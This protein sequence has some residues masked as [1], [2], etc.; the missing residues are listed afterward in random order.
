MLCLSLWQLYYLKQFVCVFSV[1]QWS[2]PLISSTFLNI[3]KNFSQVPFY[4]NR[5]F[6]KYCVFSKM[7]RY[8]PDSGLSRFLRGV[9]ECTQWQV[10]H[11][12]CN[13]RTC[14]VQKNHNILR[15]TQCLMN[16]LYVNFTT[17]YYKLQGGNICTYIKYR[18]RALLLIFL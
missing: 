6:I 11:Q 8:T 17:L 14:R 18:A 9:S 4:T 16:T 15:K 2:S 13:S 7:L 10:K 5:V 3:H 12:R 1:R